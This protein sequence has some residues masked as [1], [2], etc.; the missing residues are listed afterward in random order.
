MSLVS[1]PLPQKQGPSWFLDR[2]DVATF[3]W[4][5]WLLAHWD[6]TSIGVVQQ[7]SLF[8]EVRFSL[9]TLVSAW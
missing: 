8:N 1:C 2:S 7:G 3:G 5:P 9:R 6:F 4:V